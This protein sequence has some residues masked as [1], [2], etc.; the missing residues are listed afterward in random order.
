MH[1]VRAR[2]QTLVAAPAQRDPS[3]VIRCAEAGD[4]AAQR[5][6]GIAP[7]AGATRR[8]PASRRV[9]ARCAARVRP[10]SSRARRV[11]PTDTR[12]ACARASRHRKRRR[13]TR[14]ERVGAFPTARHEGFSAKRSAPPR[15]RPQ[16][17]AASLEFPGCCL[18]KP[19]WRY[20]TSLG[21][22]VLSADSHWV[23]YHMSAGARGG[24]R[25]RSGATSEVWAG[26]CS[27]EALSFSLACCRMRR[28]KWLL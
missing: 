11:R 7:R 10:R 12:N 22:S 16:P 6:M 19:I 15:S 21:G 5:M 17:H 24:C 14:S 9:V 26:A 27:L 25:R 23:F 4:C 28:Q 3:G 8:S 13:A 2:L 1:D 18:D 20:L